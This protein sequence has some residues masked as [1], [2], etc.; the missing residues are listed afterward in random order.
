M[1]LFI[2]SETVETLQH[3]LSFQLLYPI[4]P[5][6]SSI[7]YLLRWIIQV[8]SPWDKLDTGHLKRIQE[9]ILK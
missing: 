4:H 1:T 9:R 2:F 7:L 3:K 6:Q 8:S 5:K